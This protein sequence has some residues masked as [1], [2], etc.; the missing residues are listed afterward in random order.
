MVKW[1]MLMHWYEWE[2]EDDASWRAEAGEQ[3][4]AWQ[5][6]KMMTMMSEIGCC[7]GC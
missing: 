7:C 5:Q 2:C 1:L 6:Q 4:S 3:S